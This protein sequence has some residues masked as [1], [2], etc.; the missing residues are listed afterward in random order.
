MKLIDETGN[1][2]GRLAVM[3]R[4]EQGGSG[5]VAWQCR[6]ECGNVKVVAGAALRGGRVRSC[7]CL[8]YLDEIGHVYGKL[9]VVGY[10]AERRNGNVMWLCQCEC[11]N[12][13][14]VRGSSLRGGW[15]KSCGC[16]KSERPSLPNHEAAFNRVVASARHQAG[17]RGL[18]WS[19]TNEQVRTLHAQL[20]YYCGAEPSNVSHRLGHGRGY[21]Y[22]GLDRLYNDRGYTP[23]NVVPCCKICNTAK[24]QMTPEQFAE[25]VAGVY[26]HFV[27]RAR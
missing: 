25:W 12:E 21:V 2:Y 4:A 24:W 9:T 20:C 11:G 23:G 15:T 17:K 1:V 14:A 13:Q 26:K 5:H 22:N 16:L 10:I 18:E 27:E 19:L 6:C 8:R 7:G 3:E